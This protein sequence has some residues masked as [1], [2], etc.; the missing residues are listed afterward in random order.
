MNVASKADEG[1]GATTTC[2]SLF[3]RALVDNREA[4]FLLWRRRR[5]GGVWVTHRPTSTH[6]PPTSLGKLP[7]VSTT[8][9]CVIHMRS[10]S[11]S[12]TS[13]LILLWPRQRGGVHTTCRSIQF[14]SFSVVSNIFFTHYCIL[15][16]ITNSKC[17]LMCLIVSKC[18][19]A[20]NRPRVL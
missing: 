18:E 16:V 3:R 6:L 2:S 1:G 12:F 11:N 10:C 15:Y 19:P 20:L 8:G 14:F 17:L 13:P 4:H 5:R 7:A 9:Q